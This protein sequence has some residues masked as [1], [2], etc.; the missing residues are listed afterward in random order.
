MTHHP[1]CSKHFSTQN[2]YPKAMVLD[3]PKAGTMV[4]VQGGERSNKSINK[5][6]DGAAWK[7]KSIFGISN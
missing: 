2:Q 6:M 1:L 5:K 3:N 4:I 7:L